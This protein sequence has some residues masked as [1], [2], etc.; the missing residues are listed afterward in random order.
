MPS[1]HNR[2]L[3]M[4]G[5]LV[6]RLQQISVALFMEQA[7]DFDIT[8][9]QYAALVAIEKRPG[10][11]QTALCNIIAF[12]RSTIGDVVGRLERKKLIRRMSGAVDRRTKALYL[13]SVGRRLLRQIEPVVQSAQSLILAPLRASERNAF[14]QMLRHLVHLNNGHSRAPQRLKETRSNRAARE[15]APRRRGPR[16]WRRQTVRRE[17][18]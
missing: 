17:G 13:T 16:R 11:D 2:L 3:D 8:P 6:R 5:H 9:V 12:D 1:E 7:R 15:R 10:L 14:M 4:P 18:R